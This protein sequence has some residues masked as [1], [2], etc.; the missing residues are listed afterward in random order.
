M[1]AHRKKNHW[2]VVAITT[3][4]FPIIFLSIYLHRYFTNNSHLEFKETSQHANSSLPK[5]IYIS[6]IVNSE[7]VIA[8][9]REGSLP[10]AQ[11]KP[12]YLL[13]SP[14]P[15]DN[16]NIIIY[17]HNSSDVFGNLHT[18]KKG[19]E[20]IISTSDGTIYPYRVTEI[21]IVDPSN[22]EPLQTTNYE[23]LTLYTCTGLLDSKRLVVQ[24]LPIER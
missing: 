10:I 3:T 15:G 13:N 20:I 21:L 12:T 11:S 4:I 7:I 14:K 24:A 17:G 16:A 23:L 18:I 5:S 19:E 2:I 9:S 8:L 6:S 22:T 1:P